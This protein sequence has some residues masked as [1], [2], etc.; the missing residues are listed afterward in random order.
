MKRLLLPVCL[1]LTLM[2]ACKENR[3]PDALTEA[4]EQSPPIETARPAE[5]TSETPI[6]Q[7]PQRQMTDSPLESNVLVDVNQVA[8]GPGPDS[9]P[10][11]AQ[12]EVLEGEPPFQDEKSFVFLLKTPKN[13]TIPPHIHAVT[14]RVTVLEG[15]ASIG[16]GRKLDRK[17]AMT[18]EKGGFVALP[19]GHE[20]FFVTTNSEATIALQG[21][22]PWVIHYINPEDDPRPT[23]APKPDHKSRFDSSIQAKITNPAD[24]QWQDAPDGVLPEGAQV[25]VLE[26]DPN[27]EGK[28]Y[29]MQ[30][31]IPD[32]YLLP[33]NSDVATARVAVLSGALEVG[34]GESVDEAQLKELPAPSFVILKA[35]EPYVARAKGETIV[36][37]FGVGPFDFVR[38]TPAQVA[39]GQ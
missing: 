14:E 33:V 31:K 4:Q 26:G 23:P 38:A 13:Y 2:L 24:L 34:E 9:L 15:T 18:V 29:T 7:T 6:A 12:L 16:H 11:G 32:G 21:V 27:V 5:P 36:Q 28:T 35:G 22:G 10:K 8:F 39:A 19:A 17:A 30:V 37:F 3:K 1:L 25:A 20:H